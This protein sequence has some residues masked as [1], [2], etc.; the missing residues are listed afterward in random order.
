MLVGI[1]LLPL[2]VGEPLFLAARGYRAR[3][4]IPI[5]LSTAVLFPL[6]FFLWHGLSARIGDSWLL[7]VWPIAFAC[8]AINTK[9]A[10]ERS[11]ESLPKSLPKSL[12]ARTRPVWMV[13]SIAS[14][15]AL[16]AAAQVYYVFGTANYLKR[17]D[18]IGKEAG[19]AKVVDAAEA[20]RHAIGAQWFATT[21]YRI[22][23]L[24]RWHLRDAPVPVVQVNERRRY[25]GFAEP[26]LDGASGLYVV[27][28]ADPAGAM[29]AK[30]GAALQKVGEVDLRWRGVV[31]ETYL[32]QKLTD[33]KPVLSPPTGDPFERAQ[34]H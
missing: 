18:P 16:V 7:F 1:L 4:P 29:L 33:W 27:C 6:G 5:L 23:S 31:Y 26:A 12:L 32:F 10:L 19:F 9:H 25:L 22:Y 21:D 20:S 17:N 3:A 28:T 11:P 34:P 24:L 8:V 15:I 2:A 14:G 30:A 13:T